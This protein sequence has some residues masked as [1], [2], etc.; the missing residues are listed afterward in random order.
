MTREEWLAKRSTPRRQ[1]HERLV[2][3]GT[4]LVNVQASDP[5]R[6]RKVDFLKRC[7][8]NYNARTKRIVTAREKL[9]AERTQVDI[10]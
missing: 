3:R 1:K 5:D 10:E 7:A 4:T 9:E 8:D 2:H 6:Q